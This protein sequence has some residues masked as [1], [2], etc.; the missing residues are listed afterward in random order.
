MTKTSIYMP[1][2]FCIFRNRAVRIRAH[3]LLCLCVLYGA[4]ARAV[5]IIVNPSVTIASVSQNAVRSMF[6]MKLLQWPDGQPVRV[7]VLPDDNPLHRAFCK[8]VLDVYPYQL[9]QTWDRL[10]Y[11]GTGQAP[12]EVNSEEEML[13]SVAH[14]PGALGYLKKIKPGERV[15]TL[16]VGNS[17]RTLSGE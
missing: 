2:F 6:A 8:E 7:F 9:R 1:S 4:N 5:T 3:A 14:T 16:S 10:V 13:K 12:I 17:A 11:S 15:R